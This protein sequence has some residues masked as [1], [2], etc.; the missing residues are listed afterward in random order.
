MAPQVLTVIPGVE[1]SS[2]EG[3]FIIF[4]GDFSYL[5]SLEAFQSL[6]DR[7]SQPGGAAVV[8]VHPFAGIPGGSGVS[9][10]FIRQVARKVDGIEVYNGN[11]PD[12]KAS[13]LAREIATAYGLAELGGSDAHRRQALNRCWTEVEDVGSAVDLVQAIRAKATTATAAGAGGRS[14]GLPRFW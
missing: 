9:E 14:S 6:P 12:E 13:V 11:W 8:W 5:D 2:E 1:I 3:D 10:E 4:S 7:N